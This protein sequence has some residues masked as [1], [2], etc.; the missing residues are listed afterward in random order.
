MP[1][2]QTQHKGTVYGESAMMKTP[3]RNRD[4]A[5]RCAADRS[6]P[7]GGPH[8]ANP[9]RGMTA[10]LRQRYRSVIFTLALPSQRG[11]RR[12]R[13][14]SLSLRPPSM[15]LLIDGSNLSLRFAASPNP[16]LYSPD[17]TAPPLACS[18]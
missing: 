6:T 10:N 14:S 9:P 13:P 3:P 1:G 7:T 16:T 11:A 4:S 2:P 18:R 17:G 12:E 8:A 5:R 15:R